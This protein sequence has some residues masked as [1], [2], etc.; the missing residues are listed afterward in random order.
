LHSNHSD[1]N[2]RSAAQGRNALLMTN[3]MFL[4]EIYIEG[5]GNL[6]WNTSGPSHQRPNEDVMEQKNIGI[7]KETEILPT[8]FCVAVTKSSSD[9]GNFC[10]V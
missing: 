8:T 9:C 4:M 3:V 5:S 7:N 2:N 10:Y 6:K 1:E